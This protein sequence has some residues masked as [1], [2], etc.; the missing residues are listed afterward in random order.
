MSN[1]NLI[2]CVF[3]CCLSPVFC[4]LPPEKYPERQHMRTSVVVPCCQKHF[5][6]LRGLLQYYTEQT[7]LPDEVVISL[8]DVEQINREEIDNLEHLSWPFILKIIKSEGRKSAG[9]NRNIAVAHCSNEVVLCQDADDI[10][11]PQ[12][13]EIVKFVFENYHV[14]HLMHL[15][16]FDRILGP[17]ARFSLY[18]P[19]EVELV[20]YSIY[21]GDPFNTLNRW[22]YGVHNGNICISKELGLQYKWDTRFWHGEDVDFNVDV[23]NRP[24]RTIVVR[25]PLLFYRYGLSSFK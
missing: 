3:L 16:L 13:V 22:G 18:V 12:R 1:F 19:E 21:S 6:H 15:Y 9:D 8:S 24:F 25:A 10:P 4:A 14:D 2:L 17:E 20:H 11:H 5:K 7:Q 23:Y